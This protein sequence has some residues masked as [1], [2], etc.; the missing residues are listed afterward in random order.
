M[1]S[2]IAIRPKLARIFEFV[3]SNAPSHFRKIL[4][5]VSTNM[6]PPT[7]YHHIHPKSSKF[8]SQI[9]APN[10][11]LFDIHQA[12]DDT[13]QKR[14]S[15][16]AEARSGSNFRCLRSYNPKDQRKNKVSLRISNRAKRGV[17]DKP[18]GSWHRQK[19]KTPA[20]MAKSVCGIKLTVMFSRVFL[21]TLMDRRQNIVIS[22]LV[23]CP[24][25]PFAVVK[26]CC[27]IN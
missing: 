24:L 6:P 16:F 1:N 11:Q 15:S 14:P 22:S 20:H 7:M 2:Y 8:V 27:H 19:T 12:R 9:S 13:H 21:R 17:S 18:T 4:K 23:S 26:Q 5:T 10:Y 3:Y 25:N